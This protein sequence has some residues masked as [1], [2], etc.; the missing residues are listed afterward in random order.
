MGT[1]GQL[2]FCLDIVTCEELPPD[3]GLCACAVRIGLAKARCRAAVSVLPEYYS[4]AGPYVNAG[5]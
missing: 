2:R 1:L 4:K 3:G 5:G